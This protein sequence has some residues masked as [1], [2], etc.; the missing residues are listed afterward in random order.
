M[1]PG[2]MHRVGQLVQF[3]HFDGSVSKKV[4][5]VTSRDALTAT[6]ELQQ[7]DSTPSSDYGQRGTTASATHFQL[8][9][10]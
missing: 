7:A 4:W 3:R 2:S 5:M 10:A 8:V 6:Y 9:T 1:Y